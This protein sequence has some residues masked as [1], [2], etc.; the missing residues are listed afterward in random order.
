MEN[1]E[2]HCPHHLRDLEEIRVGNAHFPVLFNCRG[3]NATL[4]CKC[5]SGQYSL[6][7][8]VLRFARP[9]SEY[10]KP[11]K[12]IEKAGICSMCTGTTPKLVYGHE[13]YYSK[14]LQRYLPYHALL[15]RKTH[16][17][18]LYDGDPGYEHL[19]NE[20]RQFFGYGEI[21]KRWLS[22]TILYNTVKSALPKH[23]VVQH[24]RGPELEGLE[25]DIFVPKLRL[26]I[27]YQGKQHF[28]ALLHWG[29]EE[30]LKKRRS[31]DRKK[32]RICSK[33]GYSLVCFHHR[34]E[35]TYEAV[36]LKL[37]NFVQTEW[38]LGTSA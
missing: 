29:G 11:T 23:T 9:S 22:E 31:N 17:R 10:P 36:R 1:Q 12:I 35:L 5:F 8:D 25:I 30:G 32:K 15:S 26:G 24:Y 33:L 37:S 14:F 19:E 16:G 38:Q 4:T 28:K 3:C 20:L 6:D 13:M 2:D 21:G 18:D 34:E 27:E 7:D